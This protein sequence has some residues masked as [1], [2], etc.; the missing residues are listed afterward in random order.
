MRGVRT[1][2]RCRCLR[3]LHFTDDALGW[4]RAPL[5]PYTIASIAILIGLGHSVLAMSGEET[6]GAGVSRNRASRS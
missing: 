1:F 2:R 3:N 5:L 6:H 4:L